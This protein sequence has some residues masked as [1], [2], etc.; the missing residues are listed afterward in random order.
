MWSSFP[1]WHLLAFVISCRKDFKMEKKYKDS[2][3]NK[4]TIHTMI[5]I[6]PEWVASRF[7][8]M[9]NAMNMFVDRVENGEIESQ[10]TYLQFK[11]IL[12]R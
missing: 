12:G 2:N 10:R 7:T 4:A 9:E 5:K 11:Q 8:T 1:A 6:E 3:G